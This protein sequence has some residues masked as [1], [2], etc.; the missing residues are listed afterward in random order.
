[1]ATTI[2]KVGVLAN[3]S[4]LLDGRAIA[5]AELAEALDA[6]PDGDSVIWYYRENAAGEAPPI[7]LEVMKL[8]TGRRLPIRLS[9]K[10]D[11]SD[12]VTPQAASTLEQVFAAVRERAAQRMLVI[13][14]PDDQQLILPV[15]PKEAAPAD[16]VAAVE[17]LLPSSVQRRV[18]VIGDTSWSSAAQPNLRDAAGAIPF[19][20]MLMG[21]ATIGHA[22]WI[23]DGGAPERISAGCRDADLVIVD[24]GR[25]EGLQANWQALAS[26]GTRK[27][28][29]L[30]HDRA[31]YRL[32]KL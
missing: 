23:F 15:P 25:I 16:Q 9:A 6:A 12:T 13:L 22:V 14:R 4:V 29:I 17:R 31:T 1:M 8:I 2:L 3:G 24:S 11:Y 10:P 28:Q 18:A 21:L 20:G 26:A 27:P 19:F 32:R 5:L 7:T 30:V